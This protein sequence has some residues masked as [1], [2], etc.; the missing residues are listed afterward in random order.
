MNK[1]NKNLLS[2]NET[3]NVIAFFVFKGVSFWFILRVSSSETEAKWKAIC[4]WMS[5][6]G[7]C[8][9]MFGI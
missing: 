5:G 9:R 7:E 8:R 4:L 6:R 3:P 2:N 1:K